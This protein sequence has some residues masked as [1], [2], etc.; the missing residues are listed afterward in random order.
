MSPLATSVIFRPDAIFTLLK[1]AYKDPHLGFVCKMAAGLLLKLIGT[2]PHQEDSSSFPEAISSDEPSKFELS[3]APII[4]DYSSL[5]GDE[6]QLPEIWLDPSYLNVLDIGAVEEAMIH[7]LYACASQP[8]L[9]SKLADNSSNLWSVLPL[10]QALLPAL[11]PNFSTQDHVDETFLQWKQPYV[12]HALSQIVATTS[13]SVYR[14]LLHACAGYLSSF[15]PSH[16]KAA[17]V[18]IDLCSGVL[19][20][21]IAQ[22][23]AKVDLAVELLEDLLGVIQGVHH[24]MARARAALNY[25]VLALSGQMDDIIAKYRDFKHRLLFLVEML[26]PFLEPSLTPLKKI[27]PFGNV[28]SVFQEYNCEVALK[29]IHRAVRK[30]AVLPSLEYEWRRGSVAPSVLLSILEPHMELPS[31]IDRC[32]HSGS[33]LER[34]PVTS[35]KSNSQDDADGKTDISLTAVKMDVIEDAALF[36]APS[37]LNNISLSSL[38][39]SPTHKNLDAKD[40][41]ADS[42]KNDIQKDLDKVAQNGFMLESSPLSLDW[43]N[44]YF[45]H[46]QLMNFRDCELRASGFRRLAL[47]LHSEPE[48]TSESHN[49][50]IDA[51]LL[52]AE[53][54]VNPFF[55]T[56]FRENKEFKNMKRSQP[57]IAGNF[58]FTDQGRILEKNGNLLETVA[59]LESQRDKIVLQILLEA[60]KLDGKYQKI[61]E[62]DQ[63]CPLYTEENEEF[64]SLSQHDDLSMDALTLVRQNQSLLCSF[65]VQRLQKE[66]QSMHEIL[67]QCLLFLLQSATKLSCSPEL[68]IDI[69]LISAGHFNGLL[70]SYY[71]LKEG[72]EGKLNSEKMHLLRRRWMLLQRLVK[73]ASG[74]NDE[75]L[76]LSINNNFRFAN[77][78]PSSAWMQKIPTFSSSTFPLVRFFGW[79]AVARNAKLYLKEKLFLASELSQL[80]KLLT[81]YTDDL[82]LGDCIVEQNDKKIN[83]DLHAKESNVLEKASELNNQ[84]HLDLSF[85]VVYPDISHFI[86]DMKKQFEGFEE[87]IL[88]AVSLQLRSFS[89][90]AVPDLLCWFSDLCLCSFIQKEKGLSVSPNKSICFMGLAGRNAKAI[91]LYILEAMVME[92]MEAMVLEVPRVVQVL[93]AL[94]RSTICDVLFLDSVLRLLKPII[95]YSL[96]KVSHEEKLLTDS[97]CNFESLCFNELFIDLR[98]NDSDKG[99]PLE[100]ENN[101]ALAIFVL[102][103]VFPDLSFQCKRDILQ[104]LIKWADFA[105][106]EP[107][108]YFNDYLRAF[109]TIM[110]SCKILLIDTIRVHHPVMTDNVAESRSCFLIDICRSC[111]IVVPEHE[112]DKIVDQRV[113]PLSVEEIELFSNDLENLILK[114]YPTIERCWMLHHQ[115]ACKLTLEL[116]HCF[117][118]SKC[119]ASFIGDN[120]A[121]DRFPDYW[122]MSLKGFCE[123]VLILQQTH[124]W[125][126]A[127][128]NLNCVLTVPCSL[129]L[130]NMFGT[131]TSAIKNFSYNA[132]RFSW[133]VQTDKWLLSLL[134]RGIHSVNESEVS[135]ASLLGS[136]LSHP[137]PEQC[138]IALKNLG[139][140]VG[141]EADDGK[142]FLSSK[143]LLDSDIPTSDSILSAL[144]RSTWDQVALLASSDMSQLL[145]TRALALLI[146]FV[147]F[148][149]QRQLQSFLVSADCVLPW[150]GKFAHPM[151][152]GLLARLSLGLLACICLYAPAEYISLIPENIWT[153]IETFGTLN[154]EAELKIPERKVCQALCRL[155]SE[156]DDVKEVLKEVLCSNSAKEPNEEFGSTRESILQVLGN[157]TSVQSYFDLFS[158]RSDEKALELEEAEMELDLL[159]TDQ[160][161]QHESPIGIKELKRLP[162]FASYVKDSDRLQK[163]KDEIHSIEKSKLREEISARRQNKILARSAR[164]KYLEEMALRE[165]DLLQELDRERAAETEKDIERQHLLELERAKTRELRHNLEIEKEKQAQRDLQRELEQV[166]TGLR[167]STRRDFSN[168]SHSGR[169]RDRFRER[170]NVGRGSNSSTTIEPNI[171]TTQNEPINRTLSS[172]QLPTTI[173]Q[174]RDHRSDECGS[175]YEEN[176]EGDTGSIGDG[177]LDGQLI[178][179]GGGTQRNSSRGGKSRQVPRGDREGGRREGGNGK[180][181][182][183]H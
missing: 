180:W 68:V 56:S 110:E 19:A 173:L 1:K 93:V 81:I 134:E 117:I 175:S 131:I 58:E 164:Q 177:D 67:L 182:K 160:E 6:F 105:I 41:N 98:H 109:Q 51:L 72:K 82:A 157:L 62:D 16:A 23:I 136:L 83:G 143:S 145:R 21:W 113:S 96:H 18:L 20:P 86:P 107:T 78:I 12:Q 125:E 158:K 5:L 27:I 130:G 152:E 73:A 37:E 100:K 54:Y 151:S 65:I 69:I 43:S 92:H 140:L 52:A 106:F 167:P 74:G 2:E 126:V 159:Q 57:N 31:E 104:Y 121:V 168:S 147:P 24:S 64:I 75:G 95:S 25:I 14:P 112:E 133:R 102:G 26:E 66:E 87:S 38:T 153:V 156:G 91:I 116:A 10:L 76:G 59:H 142:L 47:D 30:P 99:T 36:F 40:E 11:R 124:C 45:D 3:N 150:F 178:G 60:A 4:V 22:V 97:S 15:S 61:A 53:C 172:T 8:I 181:E 144:V 166:E 80:T 71:Q 161:V 33:E 13:S 32:K 119:L 101:R 9:C 17:C 120:L 148:A 79:M 108:S 28:S 138:F 155:K 141:Q 183:K 129:C 48:I 179:M 94:C 7:V 115:L 90:A 111:P 70:T 132:P 44:L 114:L 170:E 49:A 169:N 34:F 63:T 149:E 137:E 35:S 118:Y 135:L 154:T 174:S 42:E 139:R 39:G 176:F 103:S 77:L 162:I 46:I 165:T 122:R 163:I 29:I 50:A 127:S 146:D 123:T 84:Q 128:T 171:R 55:M 85:R 88:E 89:S